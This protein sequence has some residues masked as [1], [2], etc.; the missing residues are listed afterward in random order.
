MIPGAVSFVA[1]RAQFTP[2]EVE[3]ASE[4]EKLMFRVKVRI[5]PELLARNVDKVK[6]GA[7][8]RGVCALD[9]SAEWPPEHL[10]VKLPR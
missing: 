1:P 2:K 8:R 7:A 3:T 6:T 5:D 10:R 9:P 4:R